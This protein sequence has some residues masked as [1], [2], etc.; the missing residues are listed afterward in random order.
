MPYVLKLA[1]Q[2]LFIQTSSNF[3]YLATNV[4]VLFPVVG[5]IS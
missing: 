2:T 3:A 1:I 5:F 4:E